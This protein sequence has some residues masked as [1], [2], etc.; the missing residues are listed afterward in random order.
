MRVDRARDV[1]VGG[2]WRVVGGKGPLCVCNS[3][4]EVLS[5]FWNACACGQK[6]QRHQLSLAGLFLGPAFSM[7]IF[8]HTLLC[9]CLIAF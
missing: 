5:N 6:V 7:S 2:D 3:L 4:S 8:V 1:R 9:H